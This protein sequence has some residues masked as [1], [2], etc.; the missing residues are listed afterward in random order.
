MTT[1]MPPESITPDSLTPALRRSGVLVDGRVSSV[2]AEKPRS[3]V[4]SQIVRLKLAYEGEAAGAPRTLIF[5]TGLPERLTGGWSGGRREVEFYRKVA[6][7]T[8]PGLLPRCFDAE[9][10]AE[11]KNWRLLLEDLGE[12]HK[13][14][15]ARPP[16]RPSANA[17]PSFAPGRGFMPTGA[18]TRVSASPS[19]GVDSAGDVV[20]T[21]YTGDG[22]AHGFVYLNGNY[23]TF[24]ELNVP[25]AGSTQ[26]FGVS[27]NGIVVGQAIERSGDLGFIYKMSTN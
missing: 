1:L 14:V 4:L 7:P 2:E 26:A 20:G 11:T 10:D 5:K 9:W 17:R 8:Q 27:N 6:A 16:P 19:W 23:R 21:Y 18:K 24:T 15:S 3:T 13:I 22:A 25:G 12:S